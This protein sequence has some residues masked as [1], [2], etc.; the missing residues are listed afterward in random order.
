MLLTHIGV[1]SSQHKSTN[2]EEASFARVWAA[3]LQAC[4]TADVKHVGSVSLLVMEAVEARGIEYL[5]GNLDPL[6]LV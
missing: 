6:H 5:D 2:L 3:I 4:L 1:S